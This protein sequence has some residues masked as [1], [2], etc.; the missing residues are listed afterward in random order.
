M[1]MQ[2]S[3]GHVT[4]IMPKF[5]S[6]LLRDYREEQINKFPEFMGTIFREAIKLFRGELDYL[7]YRIMAP[8]ERLDYVMDNPFIK[9]KVD[10][11][12]SEYSLIEFLFQ[13]RGESIKV[14]LYV[15]YLYDNALIIGN[16]K[17]YMHLAIIER[18]IYHVQDGIIIKVMRS[19]LQ[20]WRNRQEMYESTDGEQFYDAVVTVRAHYRRKDSKRNTAT[21]LILYLLATYE[22][23]DVIRMLGAPEGSITFVDS[24]PKD[25]DPATD[26][27]IYFPCSGIYLRV[28]RNVVY[29][30]KQFNTYRRIVAS[31]I[32]I[33]RLR[34]TVT[35]ESVYNRTFY[36]MTL[37]YILY[38]KA[39]NDLIAVDHADSHLISLST[40][41]DEYTK[42]ELASINVFCNDIY[43]LFVNVFSMIDEWSNWYSVNDLFT[44][45]IGGTDLLLIEVVKLIFN[46]FYDTQRKNKE[47][48]FQTIQKMLKLPVKCIPKQCVEVQSIRSNNAMYN[49]NE[50]LCNLIK[51]IRQ[52]SAQSGGHGGASINDKEHRFHPSFVVVESPLAISQSSPGVSGDI[53]PYVRIDHDGNFIQ[54]QMPWYESVRPLLKYLTLV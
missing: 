18:M 38:P 19:P 11:Q 17:F 41:L 10:I 12:Q 14:P 24:V 8:R 20:F 39:E 53:N 9:G 30:D 7:E 42:S 34:K 43:D 51:K 5:N 29:G 6:Y 40:Y 33:M 47:I 23:D 32:N 1:S 15:P 2:D 49:D 21:P 46:R 4:S 22:F 37:G 31:L 26:K 25:R 44:K 45:R 50:L 52:S 54:S 28:D 16:T 36:K 48:S 3:I 27:Y 35:L 13:Y